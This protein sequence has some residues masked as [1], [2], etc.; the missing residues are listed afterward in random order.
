MGVQMKFFRLVAS[1][2]LYFTHNTLL[3]LKRNQEVGPTQTAQVIFNKLRLF[4]TY[5]FV[6]FIDY[7][8]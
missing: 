8:L 5:L 7:P 3:Y 4:H 6:L 2:G 1:D